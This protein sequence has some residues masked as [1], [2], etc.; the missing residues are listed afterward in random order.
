MR[1]ADMKPNTVYARAASGY[2]AQVA[3]MVQG[4]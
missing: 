3:Q 1:L 2:M 4:G